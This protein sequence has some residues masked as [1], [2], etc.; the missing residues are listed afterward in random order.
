M[1]FD[2]EK[3]K[4]KQSDN[5]SHWTS[6]SDLF[7]ALS[8][9]FLL[10]YVVASFRTGTVTHSANVR[11]VAMEDYQRELSQQ[12][13]IYERVSKNYIEQDATEAEKELYE[14]VMKKLSLLQ[15]ESKQEQ[16]QLA[17]EL[18]E[19]KQREQEL[20]TYQ[21]TIKNLI[22][23]NLNATRDVKERERRIA[24]RARELQQTEKTLMVKQQELSQKDETL[25]LTQSKLESAKQREIQNQQ[26]MVETAERYESRIA[27]ITEESKQKL[28]EMQ[29]GFQAQQKKLQEQTEELEQARQVIVEQASKNQKL[30]AMVR[31]SQAKSRKQMD[32]VQKQHE[33]MLAQARAAYEE[34]LQ[35]QRMSAEE[36]MQAE[37]QYREK[38]QAE[39]AKFDNNMKKLES[40]LGEKLA[41]LSELQERQGRLESQNE[42]LAGQLQNAKGATDELQQKLAQGRAQQEAMEKALA[43]AQEKANRR[44]NISKKLAESF[45]NSGLDVD[46]NPDTGDLVLNFGDEYFDTGK[47]FLKSGMRE[48][49]NTAVPLYAQAIFEDPSISRFI[50]A[51]EIIGFASPTYRDRVVDPRS[52]AAKDR[53][54]INYN[55]D[56]SYKR[57]RG[58]FQYIFNTNRIKFKHQEEMLPLVKVTGRS[59]FTSDINDKNPENLDIGKFCERYDCNRSQRVVIRYN[60]QD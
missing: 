25:N 44:K 33:E 21:Q 20:N 5:G 22:Q 14:D 24:E 38:I 48:I 10:L 1:N 18:N 47:Y 41:R 6:Y 43:K 36:K 49:L 17:T 2:Y 19:Q 3:I 26:K 52:L 4:Q 9:L 31:Q 32:E 28:E 8:F 23:A 37:R 45:R 51:I 29:A 50:S 57:A 58:I 34:E 55:L 53:A 54:A 39:K 12:I 35:K 7:M 59:F 27:E 13:Q 42:E 56:L 16:Q 40:E 15:E 11:L 60:L 30:I 46:I